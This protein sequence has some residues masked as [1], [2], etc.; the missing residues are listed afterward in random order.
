MSPRPA[1]WSPRPSV[2]RPPSDRLPAVPPPGQ[3]R[4]VARPPGDRPPTG[5][6]SLLSLLAL[7]TAVCAAVIVAGPVSTAA[8][9]VAPAPAPAPAGAAP[10]GK[11]APAPGAPAATATGVPAA[12]PTLRLRAHGPAVR[13]LQ[14]LLHQPVTGWFGTRTRAAVKRFQRTHGLTV[15][16]VVG[17]LT[18]PALVA[19]A[20]SPT[21]SAI[22]EPGLPPAPATAPAAPILP[23]H[24][25][26]GAARTPFGDLVLTEAARHAG[27]P[28]VRAAVGPDSFDCSGFT[29]YVFRQLGIMLPRTSQAQ[30]NATPVVTAMDASPGDLVFSH[31]ST[32]H[33]YH[34]GIYAGGDQ[35]WDASRPG[36]TVAQRKIWSKNVSYGRVL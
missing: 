14:R 17:R 11:T 4:R 24:A 26:R 36:E 32:G 22:P 23:P 27:K 19:S 34:V 18:W 6:G 1:R 10:V 20:V 33:V 13:E 12:R 29:G 2:A 7:G 16:G 30:R 21:L 28:Y 35:M 5:F 9:A 3:R 15:S 25:S 31:D 8:G